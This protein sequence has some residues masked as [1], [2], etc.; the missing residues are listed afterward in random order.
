MARRTRRPTAPAVKSDLTPMID[1]TFLILIFFM[2][3][4]QFRTLDGKLDSRLPKESG[5]APT[6]APPVDRARVVIEVEREG[7]RLAPAGDAAWSGVGSFRYGD[8][9]VLRYTC[10]PRAVRDLAGV[11]AYLE[12]ERTRDP[13]LQ[14]VIDARRET[15][16][17][18]A[19][20][21]LDLAGL[22]GF[23]GVV[24]AGARD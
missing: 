14:L 18:D 11:R 5:V 8:D 3:T 19:V 13:E 2:L 24:L 16:Y 20:A 10:G 4:I 17:A 7:T 1:V 6:D 12:A 22:V 23:E 21:V 9:R 15:V